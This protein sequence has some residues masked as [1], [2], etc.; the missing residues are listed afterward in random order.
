MSRPKVIAVSVATALLLVLIVIALLSG[1]PDVSAA[2]DNAKW[3]IL[4]LR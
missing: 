2:Q 3:T 1:A 4:G